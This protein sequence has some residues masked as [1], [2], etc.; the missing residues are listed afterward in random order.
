MEERA[1][2]PGGSSDAEAGGH[3]PASGREAEPGSDGCVAERRAAS[4]WVAVVGTREQGRREVVGAVAA[5]LAAAGIR[6]GGVINDRVTESGETV[7][8]DVVDHATGARAALAR[9]STDPRL[10]KWGFSKEGFAAARGWLLGSTA[11]ALLLELG[12]LEAAGEGHFPTVRELLAAPGRVLVLGVRPHALARIG[13]G[14][15]DPADGIELP[16]SPA[17][18]EAFG[19][20]LVGLLR[21]S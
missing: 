9:E 7:G 19:A 8:Y 20:R 18:I 5:A 6:V 13:L 2:A 16:A 17:E 11:E 12:S 4:R 1:G 10:C 14:L 3:G 15:P 21:S